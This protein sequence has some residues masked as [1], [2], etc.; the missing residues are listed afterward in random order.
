MAGPFKMKAGKEGPMRKNFPSAFKKDKKSV[1]D[2]T[3]NT[4]AKKV[5]VLEDAYSDKDK[6]DYVSDFFNKETN[7]QTERK[8]I[9][10]NM[11]KNKAARNKKAKEANAKKQAEI[12]EKEANY[13]KKA[14]A[15]VKSGNAKKGKDYQTKD[16]LNKKIKIIKDNS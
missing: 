4:K 14:K 15:L 9:D 12:A 1:Q 3:N 10:A 6:D 8:L 2:N 11:A 13:M 5:T 16:D 7:R